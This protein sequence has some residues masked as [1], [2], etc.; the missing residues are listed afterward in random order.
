MSEVVRWAI[1]IGVSLVA[2]TA[3]VAFLATSG[4][5]DAIGM[6]LTEADEWLGNYSAYLVQGRKLI[7]NFFPP[8]ILNIAIWFGC[9]YKPAEWSIGLIRI[10]IDAV[11]KK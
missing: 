5:L 9:L 3:V 8:A 7:N 6:G 11:Y 10:I 1:I 4:Y 2:L